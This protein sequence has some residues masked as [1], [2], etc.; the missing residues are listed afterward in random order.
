MTRL[1]PVLDDV[2][3]A[4][5]VAQAVARIPALA[6]EWTDHNPTDPGITLVEL[7]A[8]LAEMLVYQ[9]D[10]LPPDRTRA[11]LRLLE[12]AGWTPT[13]DRWKNAE[14]AEGP[15]M[16]Q[17]DHGPVAFRNMKVREVK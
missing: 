2:T 17:A 1:R 3:Y 8:F 14:M 15:L 12:G 11:F 10:Q 9:A 4:D 16:L 5:L 6:P 7:F 13:G